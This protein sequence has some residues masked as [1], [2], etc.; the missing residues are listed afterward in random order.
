MKKIYFAGGCFWGLEA[1][2][3]RMPWI[4]FTQ[5]GYANG[6]DGEVP[7]YKT[8]QQTGHAETVEVVYDEDALALQTLVRRF[9]EVIDPLSFNRQGPDTGTQY[10]TAVYYVPGESAEYNT[11]IAAV[12]K[13]F[14]ETAKTLGVEELATVLEPLR[15]WFPAEEYHQ[16][17]VQKIPGAYCH[18]PLKNMQRPWSLIDKERYPRPSPE[19]LR[20]KL[21]PL[22]FDVVENAA[23]ELA[24]TGELEHFFEK[25]IYVDKATG[26]PLFVSAQKYHSG[27][28][29][30]AFSKPIEEGVIEQLEDLSIPG[31][32]RIEVRSSSGSHLGHVFKDGPVPEGRAALDP[33]ADPNHRPS[34][35]EGNGH[36]LPKEPTGLRYCINSAALR[37][38]AFHKMEDEG[39]GYLKGLTESLL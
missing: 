26:E 22:E 34:Q 30:P 25:G 28:G 17:Y 35:P 10:R 36:E 5:A 6:K 33:S 38:I 21:Q 2:F 27:C 9:F 23:T 29:W 16:N 15:N 8:L 24:G 13:V 11:T 18:I 37:F 7:V 4:E 12:K 32:P 19:E 31:R 14:E 39:Y 3:R 20:K 1:Y